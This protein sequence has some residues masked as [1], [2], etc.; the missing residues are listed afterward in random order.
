MCVFS[1]SV[2]VMRRGG[3]ISVDLSLFGLLQNTEEG[4]VN[5]V[6]VSL[7]SKCLCNCRLSH[8]IWWGGSGPGQ[9]NS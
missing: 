2:G 1:I 6:L 5:L 7:Y 9:R 4:L 8:G 3:N